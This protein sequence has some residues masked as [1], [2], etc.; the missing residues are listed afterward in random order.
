LYFEIQFIKQVYSIS[1]HYLII[2]IMI[3]IILIIFIIATGL[4]FAWR[5]GLLRKFSMEK[6][7]LMGSEILYLPYTGDY[8]KLGPLFEEVT[9]ST[10]AVFKFS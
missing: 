2:R 6:G 4:Y 5:F 9:R 3:W 1:A 10:Q 7:R 8:H